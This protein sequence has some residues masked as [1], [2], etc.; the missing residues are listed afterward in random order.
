MK[1][2]LLF[3]LMLFIVIDTSSE[4]R[5]AKF[6]KIFDKLYKVYFMELKHRRI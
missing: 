4:E 6:I 5:K 3:Y 1:K 2:I